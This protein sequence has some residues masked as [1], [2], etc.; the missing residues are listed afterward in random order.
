VT[1]QLVIEDSALPAF[2][3]LFDYM[4]LESYKMVEDGTLVVKA[5]PGTWS[6]KTAAAAST[7]SARS[8]SD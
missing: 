7:Q 4:G 3:R 6:D 1:V 5:I 2:V 8:V